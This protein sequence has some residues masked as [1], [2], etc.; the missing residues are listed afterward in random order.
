MSLKSRFTAGALLAWLIVAPSVFAVNISS[1]SPGFAAPGDYVTIYGSGFY[2]GVLAVYFGGVRDYT[3]QATAADGTVIQATVPNGA[4]T[5][6]I[7]VQVNTVGN[8]A[9]SL[10]DFIVIGAG[11]YVTGFV[12]ATG[13][14]NTPVTIYGTHFDVGTGLQVTFDGK[15]GTI[16]N[17]QPSYVQVYAPSTVTT[18]PIRVSSSLG[19]Y[20]TTTNF[21]VPP[22]LI[23][24]S[25]TN[26][27][28]GTNVIVTGTNFRGTLTVTFNG[29]NALNFSVL[30]NGALS[31]LAPLNVTA[32]K[33]RVNAPAGS[34]TST[35]TFTVPPTIFGFSPGFGP[36]GS[37]VILSGANFD[38]G[39]PTVY[40]NGAQ[41]TINGFSFGSITSSVPA[42]ATTGPISVTTTNGS[43]TSVT[44][45]Y[46]PPT[47]TSFTPNNSGPGTT[48]KI[49]GANLTNVSAVS[50]NGLPAAAFWVTNSS[51]V[52]AVVPA[53]LATGPISITTPG[54][55][56]TSSGLF[57][58][59]PVVTGFSPTSGL[60]GTN[61]TVY[62]SNFL[63]ANYVLFKGVAAAFTA[64]NNNVLVA[65]VPPN[66]KTGPITVIAPGGTNASTS[67]FTLTYS[68]DVQL[69]A[70]EIPDPVAVGSNL[71]YTF[72]ITNGG[73]FYAPNVHLSS[74]LDPTVILKSGYTSLGTW[75]NT[76]TL[77]TADL[78][79]IPAFQTATLLFSVT[80]SAPGVITNRTEISSDFADPDTTN[81]VALLTTTVQPLP[82]LSIRLSSTN[83]V[84]VSWPAALSDFSLQYRPD[85]D[86]GGFW[87]NVLATPTVI[88]DENVVT[89]RTTNAAR[90][91][92]LQK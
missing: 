3:A 31:V 19:S 11:P 38:V 85:V 71:L 78:G 6:P 79:T 74:Q 54:G 43:H 7:T 30:S 88:G 66:A 72:V 23:G 60:P 92:R 9:S 13:S 89:E 81:N 5:G 67:D 45:F 39:T 22:T 52:G 87:S 91:Y 14:A 70:W 2:P 49:T 40:F 68:S 76:G 37:T 24:F 65:S 46:L 48:V 56:A 18:G 75:T 58:G 82:I 33:I 73:P 29:T 16:W 53:G 86:T 55:V 34:A 69:R 80:P 57:F 83:R 63:G 36:V 90:L 4:V 25:P 15:A 44:L 20:T 1:F 17:V 27:R 59:P 28:T 41:A 35:G 62:G 77:V 32:G 21:F 61:V 50:F 64:T 42:S 12:P 10:D 47:I 84:R 8:S 26:G 51:T